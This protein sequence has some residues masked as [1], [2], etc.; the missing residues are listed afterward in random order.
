MSEGIPFP[1]SLGSTAIKWQ[2]QYLDELPKYVDKMNTRTYN[3]YT[4]DGIYLCDYFIYTR[5]NQ[6]ILTCYSLFERQYIHTRKKKTLCKSSTNRYHFNILRIITFI[7]HMYI[8]YELYN[9]AYI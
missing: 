3:D 7:Y 1:L 5:V 2:T 6:M 8:E 4:I 9:L